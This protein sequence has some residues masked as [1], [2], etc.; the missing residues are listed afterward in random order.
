MVWQLLWVTGPLPL[1]EIP[2]FSHTE[3]SARVLMSMLAKCSTW[4]TCERV[5]SHV[6]ARHSESGWPIYNHARCGRSV[7]MRCVQHSTQMA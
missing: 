7:Q 4:N 5:E 3:Q 2:A 6:G 1:N